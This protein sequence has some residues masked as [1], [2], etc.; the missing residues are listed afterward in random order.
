MSNIS[1]KSYLIFKK[2][3]YYYNKY[4]FAAPNF[5][6]WFRAMSMNA[7]QKSNNFFYKKITEKPGKNVP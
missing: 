6:L 2:V 3:T 5:G 1:Y 7:Y 4:E